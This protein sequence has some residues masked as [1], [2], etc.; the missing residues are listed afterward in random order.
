MDLFC[1]ERCNASPTSQ[2]KKVECMKCSKHYFSNRNSIHDFCLSPIVVK[3]SSNQD[4]PKICMKILLF[5][6]NYSNLARF[7]GK[8]WYSVIVL[9]VYPF[10][11]IEGIKYLLFI[12]FE[13]LVNPFLK[14]SK[15]LG[16][17][18]F[19][20]YNGVQCTISCCSGGTSK[21]S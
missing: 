13:K 5:G 9:K 8:V 6:G 15:M 19:E 2:N 4:G 7:G 10:N 16:I 3:S 18:T 21:I 17:S 14:G 12:W 20:L 1:L 11:L